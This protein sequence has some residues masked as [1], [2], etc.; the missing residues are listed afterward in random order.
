MRRVC[1]NILDAVGETPVIPLHRMVEPG[2][3][4][5]FGKYEAGNPTSSLKDRVARQLVDKY[6]RQGRLNAGTAIVAATAGNTGVALAMVA[7][8]QKLKLHLFMSEDA[9]L[10]KRDLFTHFGATVHITDAASGVI[11]ARTAALDFCA[12]HQRALFLDQFGD[13]AVV[14]AHAETTAR[15]IVADFPDGMDAFVMGVGTAGTI[16][17]VGGVLRERFPKIKIIAVEPESSA[18]LSGG[19]PGKSH[20]QQLG[21]GFVPKNFRRE[22]VDEVVKVSDADAYVMAKR[23]AREEALLLGLSSGANVHVALQIARDLGAGKSV[24]TVFCD[25]GQ[26]YF[27]LRRY[28]EEGAS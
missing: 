9:S 7:A 6:R 12:Q 17:G 23:L 13:D 27:S 11:G 16:S 1:E 3:A 4:A 18:V 28:F 24:L 26:R 15:E 20:I 5:V 2:G 10:E 21:P 8:V 14:R 19:P 25:Q 22:L